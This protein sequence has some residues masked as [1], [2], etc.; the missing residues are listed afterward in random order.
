MDEWKVR[1]FQCHTLIAAFSCCMDPKGEARPS[2]ENGFCLGGE[3]LVPSGCSWGSRDCLDPVGASEAC[4]S[5]MEVVHGDGGLLLCIAG[6]TTSDDDLPGVSEP[7]AFTARPSMPGRSPIVKST[8]NK[9][10]CN[11]VPGGY[12]NQGGMPRRLY[13]AICLL[14]CDSLLLC[15]CCST[16]D[17]PSPPVLGIIN[18][19][20]QL[21]GL[22][23]HDVLA[24]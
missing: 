9:S 15:W 10:Y 14:T 16:A 21:Q 23:S 18:N 5:V 3:L 7:T 13:E 8:T 6:S 19:R 11:Q 1:T 2:E 4:W 20:C 17:D 12:R 22:R 24:A